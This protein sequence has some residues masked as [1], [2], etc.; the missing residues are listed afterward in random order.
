MAVVVGGWGGW[1]GGMGWVKL[2]TREK[3]IHQGR[4][5]GGEAVRGRE[6]AEEEERSDRI[7]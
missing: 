2:T 5:R 6:V 4:S 7:R 3:T 1:R